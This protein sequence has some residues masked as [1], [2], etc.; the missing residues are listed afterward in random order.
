MKIFISGGCKNGKSSFAQKLAFNLA[1]KNGGNPVYFATM[2]PH[3]E[4]DEERIRRHRDERA[5]LN[6]DTIEV[7]ND[8]SQVAESLEEGR[9]IL[10][11]SFT[12]LLAAQIFE[13]RG[14]F[15]P[16][17]IEDAAA[18]ALEEIQSAVRN[19][20]KKS[21]SVIFVSDEIYN[22]GKY[23]E[24]TEIYKKSL[25]RL[26]QLVADECDKIYELS[27]GFEEDFENVA[28]PETNSALILGGAFQGKTRFAK[29]MFSLSD[30]DIFICAEESPPDFS[31]TCI[32]H[33][34]NYVAWCLKNNLPPMTNFSGSKKKIIICDD[35]FCGIVPTDSFQRKLR[36][37]TGKALQQ[38]AKDMNLWR[39]FCGIG[40][41]LR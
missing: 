33:Y 16:S 36:E 17:A 7:K 27:A 12:A 21:D 19:L 31:K 29:K 25:A 14:D 13:G 3:D 38:I 6:F 24:L 4:E 8:F 35:I 11:D 39:V 26:E 22:D 23:D 28:S 15:S 10:L 9:V 41:R 30:D 1:Q 40:R 18:K 37:E 5:G 34:E 32:S 20:M 2:I